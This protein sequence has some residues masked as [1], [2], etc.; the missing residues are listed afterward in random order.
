MG[1]DMRGCPGTTHPRFPSVRQ[2]AICTIEP[3]GGGVKQIGGFG[4]DPSWSANGRRVV[5]SAYNGIWTMRADGTDKTKVALVRRVGS[6]AFSPSGGRIVYIHSRRH[7]PIK[8]QW[9][10]Y[11]IRADGT[12]KRLIF[13]DAYA[14]ETPTYSPD[15]SRIVFA[16][17][18][19]RRSWGVWTMQP[20]GTDLRPVTRNPRS[21]PYFDH[22]PD[23]SPDGSQIVFTRSSQ[24]DLGGC[25]T[26]V[27]FI[28]PD[29]SGIHGNGEGGEGSVRYAPSGDLLV[30]S[31]YEGGGT[32]TPPYCGDIF[33]VPVAGGARTTVTDNCANYYN[34]LPS[35]F[36]GGPRWQPLPGG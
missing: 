4:S 15:G 18:P 32:T 35:G 7:R 16:G 5:F 27:K 20:D 9:A 19:P 11:A 6:P 21:S 26:V 3:N 25:S 34:G 24:C 2:V 17:K 8:R 23:W 31:A 28:R 1:K 22:Y 10:I 14:P 29:G 36:A 12:G 33:T 30:S 13:A